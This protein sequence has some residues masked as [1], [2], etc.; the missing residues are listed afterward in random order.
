MDEHYYNWFQDIGT[1][2]VPFRREKLDLNSVP[3]HTFNFQ[4]TPNSNKIRKRKVFLVKYLRP[5]IPKNSQNNSSR[6]STGS[7]LKHINVTKDERIT[8]KTSYI[9]NR[10]S[11][12]R[13]NTRKSAGP[14]TR[15]ILSE[16]NFDYPLGSRLFDISDV[17]SV[18]YGKV[19]IKKHR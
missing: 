4:A 10:L 13:P 6:K 19:N 1:S 2:T 3:I 11:P 15:R 7:M 18:A 17:L 5:T 9:K 14:V 12:G 16:V 8:T